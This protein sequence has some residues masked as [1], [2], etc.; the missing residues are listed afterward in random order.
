ML[1]NQVVVIKIKLNLI[2]HKMKVLKEIKM[3]KRSGNQVMS[4]KYKM[5]VSNK[6]SKYH[7]L[8]SNVRLV[9]K[10]ILQLNQ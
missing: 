9:G 10:V 4:K 5:I 7:W 8:L 3:H 2:Y 1:L 6:I